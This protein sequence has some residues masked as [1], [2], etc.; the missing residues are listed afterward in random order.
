MRGTA[1]LAAALEAYLSFTARRS[2]GR[3]W[4]R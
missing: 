4:Q 2:G 3:S 1:R